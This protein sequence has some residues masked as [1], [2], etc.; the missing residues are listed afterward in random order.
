MGF[1]ILGRASM[2]VREPRQANMEAQDLRQKG[3]KRDLGI[4]ASLFNYAGHAGTQAEGR[5]N[6]IS[7]IEY[8]NA[9]FKT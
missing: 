7:N 1:K 3:K 8:R 2:W 6:D 4:P 5:T 9:N